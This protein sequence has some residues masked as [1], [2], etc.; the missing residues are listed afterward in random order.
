MTGCLPKSCC[1]NKEIRVHCAC[2]LDTSKYVEISLPTVV[3]STHKRNHVA[4]GF[5]QL[6][7]TRRMKQAPKL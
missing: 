7:R 1:C 3:G 5:L 6:Y 4:L 2:L